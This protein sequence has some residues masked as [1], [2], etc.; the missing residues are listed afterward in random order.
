[1]TNGTSALF[2]EDYCIW[3]FSSGR[4][5][6]TDEE[7]TAVE[8]HFEQFL[9]LRNGLP[10]KKSI[11]KCLKTES[12]VL[13]HRTWTNVKDYLRNRMKRK[14]WLGWNACSPP[15]LN[16]WSLLQLLISI[17]YPC[18]P[19]NGKAT[20]CFELRLWASNWQL[21]NCIDS[22]CRFNSVLFADIDVF[23]STFNLQGRALSSERLGFWRDSVYWT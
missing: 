6:W 5:T 11:D 17:E 14:M 13:K 3:V 8:K 20:V 9:L 7:V 16:L 21:T 10:G 23:H 22:F 15:A 2:L 19:F 1:M 4:R 18:P 12:A